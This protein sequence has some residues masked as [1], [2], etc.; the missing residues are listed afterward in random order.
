MWEKTA[1][2]I[3]FQDKWRETKTGV[4]APKKSI[5]FPDT[6]FHIKKSLFFFFPRLE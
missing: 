2:R 5:S 6:C 4:N 3:K 1:K